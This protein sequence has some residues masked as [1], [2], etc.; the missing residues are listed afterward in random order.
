M[1]G[2]SFSLPLIVC[3]LRI[4]KIA[5]RGREKESPA[6]NY[7]TRTLLLNVQVPYDKFGCET[8]FVLYSSMFLSF[9]GDCLTRPELSTAA[10]KGK[11]IRKNEETFLVTPVVLE[12]ETGQQ[13]NDDYLTTDLSYALI[14]LKCIML[15][16]LYNIRQK[17]KL[18]E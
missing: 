13:Q 6:T 1:A 15:R 12:Q 17:V 11:P 18:Y 3:L 9:W 8:N 4:P 2:L 10:N 16:Q 5:K 14:C 7:R